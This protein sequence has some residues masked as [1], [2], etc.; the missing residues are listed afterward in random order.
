[1]TVEQARKEIAELSEALRRYNHEYFVLA[2]PSVSDLDYD[3]TFDRLKE[4][5]E[6]FPQLAEPDSP[7]KRVGSDLSSDLPEAEHTIPVLSLDKAYSTAEI[8]AWI[9]KTVRAAGRDLSF[10]IEEKIDGVSIVLYYESGRLSRAITR[11][12]GYVGNDVTANVMTVRSVPLRLTADITVAVRGE[13]YLEKTDFERLNA[14]MDTPY[15]NPRN[16]AAGTIRRIKSSEVAGFPLKIFVYG[17]TLEGVE[18]YLDMIVTLKDLGFRVNE[19]MGFFSEDGAVPGS[20]AAERRARDT[21]AAELG[22]PG[23]VT[24]G[25]DEIDGYLKEQFE[26]RESLPYEIDGLVIKVNEISVREALGYTGHHPRWEIAYK[27]DAPEGITTIKAIDVQVGRTGRITPVARVEPVRIGGSTVSNATLHN[28]DYINLLELCVGDTVAVS[29]RGDVIPAVERV[30][31]KNESNQT[32][33]KMPD[34]CPSCG[35]PLVVRGAHHFCRNFE[36]PAQVRGRLY[37]FAGKGQMDI[38]NLGPETLDTLISNGSIKRPEDIYTFDYDTLNGLPGFGEKKV[39]LLKKGVEESRN[40]PFHTVL[41]SLGL[42]EL[43][44]NVTELLIE[45]GYRDIESLYAAAD[46]NDVAS[47]TAIPGI[48]EKTAAAVISELKRPEVRKT[49]AAL[50]AEGLS[51]SETEENKAEDERLAGQTW[52]VTGSFDHFKPRDLAMEAVKRLGGRAVSSVSGSTTHLLAGKGA[53]SKLD[54][55]KEL[56]VTIVSEEE[57]LR[58]IGETDG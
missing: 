44:P 36:C 56:G 6:Q 28:Q 45:A 58:L 31:E 50:R 41:P 49:I 5:E 33:W 17:G 34:S 30:I 51:F 46:E 9:T 48:G 43:G 21:R 55:A 13:L 14:K 15:A 47:L 52:C 2:S 39:S 11:G 54:K 19:H 40:R 18:S 27:F 8:D 26:R 37:F 4:L 32:T 38:D 35:N 42:P 53:G 10:T 29:K 1:M 23:L 57:F 20:G 16:L 12:N 24:G 25:F 22:V 3:K 7:V